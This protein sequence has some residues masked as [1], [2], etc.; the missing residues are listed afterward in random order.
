MGTGKSWLGDRIARFL[1]SWE[2]A[3]LCF[4]QANTNAGLLDCYND[5]CDKS[6]DS[7]IRWGCDIVSAIALPVS[8]SEYCYAISAQNCQH[9][10]TRAYT[11]LPS[12][13]FR[14]RMVGND[15]VRQQPSN[16][17]RETAR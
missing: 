8:T 7:G 15:R 9:T 5:P 17:D 4:L 6:L 16:H 13:S 1:R 3:I 14:L 12:D 10:F 2:I 11:D